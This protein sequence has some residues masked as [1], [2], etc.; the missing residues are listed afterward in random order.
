MTAPHP[1]L[2]KKAAP[3]TQVDK[4]T[5]SLIE[6]LKTTLK[7]QKNPAGVGLAF[8]QIGKSLRAFAMREAMAETDPKQTEIMVL[9]NPEIIAHSSDKTLGDDEEN[10]DLEGCLSIPNV[11]G[12]VP[13]WA[14]VKL[15]YQILRQNEL[16]DQTKK[17]SGFPARIAQHELDHLNGILFTDY[18]L[19]LNLPAYL[20][21][22]ENLVTLADTSPLQVY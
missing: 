9:I 6:E 12:P 19:E 4:K 5:I 14:W 16:I 8:P 17:F 11:Y 22:E 3:I 18:L 13:R 7:D 20:E 1:T 15:K 2:R 10:P 21:Q